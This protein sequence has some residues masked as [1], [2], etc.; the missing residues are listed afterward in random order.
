[1]TDD[2]TVYADWSAL[3]VALPVLGGVAV[4]ALV[5]LLGIRAVG[6]DDE[7]PSADGDRA[8]G[9]FEQASTE[10]STPEEEIASVVADFVPR[11]ERGSFAGLDFAFAESV[12]ADEDWATVTGSLGPFDIR[13]TPGETVI[14]DA[15][16]ASLPVVVDW[17]LE[18]GVA[19][20]TE[21]ELDLVLIGTDWLVDWEPAILERTLD[22]GDRLVW[23]RVLAPRA[24]I[25]GRG[26]VALVDNRAVVDIGVIPRQAGDI[27]ELSER[28]APLL[29]LDA[30]EIQA[31][32]SPQ[33]SDSLVTLASARAESVQSLQGQLLAIPGV[34]LTDSTFPLPPND[35]FGRALLGRSA[36]VTAEIIDEAPGVF[37]VGDIA[38]RSGLQRIYNTRLAGQPGFQ[39]RVDRQFP[40]ASADQQGSTV[41]VPSTSSTT[42]PDGEEVAPADGDAAETAPEEAVSA[43]PDVVFLSAPVEGT[44]LRLTIDERVQTA[45]ENALADTGLTSALVAIEAST[46]HILAAANGPDAAVNNFA[47][48]GRYPPG[49][50][51][52]IITAYAAMETGV[53]PSDQFEC[54]EFLT[55]NGREFTNAEGEQLGSAPLRRNFRLSCNTGFI[56][57]GSRLAPSAFPATGARFGLGVGYSLGT[58]AFSGNVP[59]PDGSVDQAATSFGQG[60]IELSP[61]SAAVMAASAASGSYHP[62]QLI[63]EPGVD[64][65]APQP[66]DPGLVANLQDMM[67]AVVT[68][69]TGGAVNGVQGGPVAG[70]TGTAE[71]G[72]EDPPEAHAWFVGFQGDLAFAVFV[73]GGEFGGSTAAP[74]AGRFLNQLANG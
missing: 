7:T 48:T 42:A 74:I 60:R 40:S 73:E 4:V 54:P 37:V 15:A 24:P 31:T 23:E 35:R 5:A 38:G 17:T 1:M 6:S 51:F 59:V 61:L 27:G 8:A 22:P 62:P 63:L 69:G 56:N 26:D 33:P 55:V 32:I 64:P 39:I 30:G 68:N 41:T 20:Q 3:R 46:G 58:D 19:F 10:P 28:L 16:N 52:K 13:V 65:P 21:G 11:L 34:V 25:L 53:Q 2:E 9:S 14:E 71:F 29:N 45:A 47:F 49:S 66:L 44:P 12:E 43:D 67:R 36:E 18:D 57:I 72:N 50:I 70:K